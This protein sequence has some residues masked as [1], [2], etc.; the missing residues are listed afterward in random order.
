MGVAVTCFVLAIILFS[1]FFFYSNALR[2]QSIFLDYARFFLHEI[3]GTFAYIFIYLICLAGFI[4]LITF[5]HVAFSSKSNRNN[6]FWD[7]TNPGL[8][9]IFNILEFIWGLQ[10]LRDACK[11]NTI[12]STSV[13]LEQLPTGTGILTLPG[14]ILS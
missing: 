11:I 14:T 2:I 1:M 8:L 10:F 6:N 4:A 5:Q 7:L 13:F 9:G 3:R 12:Q